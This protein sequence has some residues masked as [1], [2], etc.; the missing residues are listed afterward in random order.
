MSSWFWLTALKVAVAIS[1]MLLVAPVGRAQE[2]VTLELDRS[3][4]A[5]LDPVH[6][7]EV[8]AG[9]RYFDAVRAMLVRFPGAAQKIHARLQDGYEIEKA[10]LVLQWEDQEGS[11]PQRGRSGW[12]ADEQYENNPG[13][14]HVI[15]RLLRRP[16][17]TEDPDLGPTFNAYVRGLGFWRRGGARGDG[18]DRFAKIFG[19]EPLH[20]KEEPA[21][22]QGAGAAPSVDDALDED[23]G[24]ADGEDLLPQDE[25]PPPMARLD[26]T[27]TLVNPAYGEGMGERLR[28]VAECGFQVHKKEIRD[29]SYRRF[30]AYDWAVNIG[31]MRIWIKQPRLV[32][33]LRKAPDAT[34]EPL[35]PA[36]DVTE[37]AEELRAEGGR[38]KPSVYY[39]ENLPERAASHWQQPEGMPDW[40]W[41]R[42]G[43]L[44]ALH[45]DPHATQLALGR[46]F[47]W[48]SLFAGDREAYMSAMREL[49]RMPPR[50][51]H[52]HL[53]SD[54]ALLPSA[55][56]DLL[57]EGVMDH[58][59]L[60]WK[61]W[62]H[63]EVERGSGRAGE[64][65]IGG[66]R[67]RGGPTY[68]RGYSDGGGTMNFGHNAVMGALLGSQVIDAEYPLE[69]A[70]QGLNRLLLGRNGL[71]SGAHQEIGDTYYQALSLAS[72]TAIAHFA[73]SPTDRL[74]ARIHRDQ[75]LEALISM[76][77]PG[78]RRLTHPMGRG[79]F[80]YHL[81]LQ[82]GPYHALHTLSREGTLIHLED[83]DEDRTRPPATW[84]KVHGLSILGNEAP[85]MR[86]AVLSPWMEPYLADPISAVLDEKT[87]PW[88]V[89]ARDYSPG[90]RGGG[91]HVNY[92]NDHY[93]LASR[94][95]ANKNYG[96]TSVIAQWRR[97]PEQVQD[98][99]D[100]GH[101]L[102]DFSSNDRFTK[103]A[104]SMAEFGIVQ[105]NNK[106]IAMKRLPKTES[107]ERNADG[108]PILS[109]HTS[110]LLLA[111]GDTSER[112][113]WIND[114]LAEEVSG[115]REVPEG[116]W[117][118]RIRSAG[119]RVRA[120]D[121]DVITIRDGV[122]YLGL[123]PVTANAMS[124]RRE[125]EI[126]FEP[127]IM[128]I[129]SYIYDMGPKVIRDGVAD[130]SA[131]H[132]LTAEEGTDDMEEVAGLLDEG[133]EKDARPAPLDL[134][135]LQSL[136]DAPTA[137]FV[138]EMGDATQYESFEA[139]R[140]HMNEVAL[141]TS[142]NEEKHYL[143]L[144]YESGEDVLEMSYD[145][146]AYP[147]KKRSINGKWPYL[148][149]K[150]M[151]ES[152]WA[153]QGRT[154][155][156]EKN[157]ARLT[158]ADDR[159]AYLL[160]S[161]VSDL[162]VAYNPT[163]HRQPWRLT[164]PE[165]AEL[166]TDGEVGLLRVAVRREVNGVWVDHVNEEEAEQSGGAKGLMLF[167]FAE[168][169]DVEL[170]GRSVQPETRMIDGREAYYVPF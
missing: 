147:A 138:V 28:R 17:S 132:V 10:E 170:N 74:K 32:V 125:V 142:W 88:T 63:P 56:G 163:P 134:N 30:W 37:L 57:S 92:L 127:P 68:F 9:E 156:L 78:T 150:I 42:I 168:R 149:Q 76:Y 66:G 16:W 143:D 128:L 107:I 77:H 24:M 160:A 113:V 45:R 101:M 84:G 162:Y 164:L 167:G 33:T 151:R 123:I 114:E 25:P 106:M 21:E 29:M 65:N 38:G 124:R 91:W 95:N 80:K 59:K 158:T 41:E 47:N 81:L 27:E 154:G 62:L 152:N 79:H 129:H 83:L 100:S 61:A 46:S 145:P 35:P 2:S 50:T 141:E 126:A 159:H 60:Y 18:A 69:D 40:Q 161:P 48:Y 136:K 36:A 87:Y 19:P 86:V 13:K 22:E 5:V 89:H 157:G 166:R 110:A 94:D 54:F 103:S 6:W 3:Q 90:C 104:L 133:D 52:G 71:R 82:E 118:N 139:F 58:L 115:A 98:L 120:S 8:M 148:P 1:G 64:K 93:A 153:I 55:Y 75:L 102:P 44:R 119:A 72:P 122:T 14:W 34:C 165:G 31:Y 23:E 4:T 49:L 111:F 116:G 155:E 11:R 131:D 73:E 26:V 15:A 121:G 105:H 96:V 112:Q 137:G 140:R 39:L 108:K 53:S 109:L 135:T 20:P 117:Q 12:G 146:R 97:R 85:P 7:D 130:L 70:R 43:D 169:P 67:H 144:R 51:W 99:N